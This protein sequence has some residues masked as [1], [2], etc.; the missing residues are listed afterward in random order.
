MRKRGPS[1][2]K[3][4]GRECDL[5]LSSA[6]LDAGELTPQKNLRLEKPGV[7][8]QALE[9]LGLWIRFPSRYPKLEQ[10]ASILS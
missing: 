3:G 6:L 1:A 9:K 5:R 2:V 4:A 8:P 10:R 7:L